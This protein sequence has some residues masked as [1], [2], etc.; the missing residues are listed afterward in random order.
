VEKIKPNTMVMAMGMSTSVCLEVSNSK[1]VVRRVRRA[2]N[3]WEEARGMAL[4]WEWGVN[5]F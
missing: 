1:G 4:S 3:L 2:L 5:N